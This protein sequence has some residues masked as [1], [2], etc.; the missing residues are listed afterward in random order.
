[1]DEKVTCYNSILLLILK[2]LR[3]E[4][5][6]PSAYIA[7]QLNRSPSSWTK[8]ENGKSAFPMDCLFQA[9]RAL[10]TPAS[11][12]IMATER[13]ATLLSQHQWAVLQSPLKPEDDSVL[14]VAQN[15]YDSPGFKNQ[16]QELRASWVNPKVSVSNSPLFYQD[17]TV[18]IT[19]LFRYIVDNEFKK[20]Y[21]NFNL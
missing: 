9:A 10:W 2:E 3:L 20:N 16:N 14:Q 4:K 17:G 6:I 19:D 1:M 12:I 18:Q 8:I 7:E 21:D 11:T 13:Y 15:Y 5:N